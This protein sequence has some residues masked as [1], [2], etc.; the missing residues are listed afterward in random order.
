MQYWTW[1]SGYL[2]ISMI[3]TISFRG[4]ES[5]PLFIITSFLCLLYLLAFFL[6]PI[7]ATAQEIEELKKTAEIYKAED[8]TA[9]D[10]VDIENSGWEVVKIYEDQ[11]DSVT[12]REDKEKL[13]AAGIKS[14]AKSSLGI[15]TIAVQSEDIE[16]ACKALEIEQSTTESS[17]SA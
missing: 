16:V 17:P 6:W 14:R 13:Y 3:N 11:V 15:T 8:K 2:I 1:V 5:R 9:Q 12:F 10:R 4:L 7:F